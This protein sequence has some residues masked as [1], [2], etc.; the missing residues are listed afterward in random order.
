MFRRL[1][2]FFV[3]KVKYKAIKRLCKG[4]QPIKYLKR[5]YRSR[6]KCLQT[7]KDL[8]KVFGLQMSQERPLDRRRPHKFFILQKISKSYSFSGRIW[9]NIP[10]ILKTF[11]DLEKILIESSGYRSLWRESSLKA[12]VLADTVERFFLKRYIHPVAFY[13]LE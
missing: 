4:Q 1:D 10:L 7:T 13:K 9:I 6:G 3:L 8:G 5:I 2:G 12:F 11:G